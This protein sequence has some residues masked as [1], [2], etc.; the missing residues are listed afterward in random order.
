MINME[1]T[2]P[3]GQNGSWEKLGLVRLVEIIVR[4]SNPS[5][6]W[7][8]WPYNLRMCF[9]MHRLWVHASLSSRFGQQAFKPPCLSF[10]CWY[11]ITDREQC[12]LFSEFEIL[13]YALLSQN[14]DVEIYAL[15]GVKF[16]RLDLRA[17]V[18]KRFAR[19]YALFPQFFFDWKVEMK[20]FCR[21]IGGLSAGHISQLLG[22]LKYIAIYRIHSADSNI[23]QYIRP[24]SDRVKILIILVFFVVL[25]HISLHRIVVVHATNFNFS[26]F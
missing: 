10:F 18:A 13:I 16:W 7:A 5:G 2:K 8:Y 1:V 9:Q 11:L 23:S 3:A 4:I 6:L 14:I 22:R 19:I 21:Y 17:F 12:V 26:F 25:Q 24:F 20:L 15:F